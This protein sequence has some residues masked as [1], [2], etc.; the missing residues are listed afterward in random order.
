M[1][2]QFLS[3]KEVSL[4][5][6]AYGN[7]L[8]AKYEMLSYAIPP[9]TALLEIDTIWHDRKSVIGICVPKS[10]EFFDFALD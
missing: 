8:L 7:Y 4:N 9:S 2:V 1:H 6:L 5:N 3:N 10:F